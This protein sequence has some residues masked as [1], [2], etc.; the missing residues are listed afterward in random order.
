MGRKWGLVAA[1][2]AV[3]A[4]AGCSSAGMHVSSAPQVPGKPVIAVQQ[5]T[6]RVEEA[7]MVTASGRTAFR[8]WWVSGGYRQ[9]EHVA[10]DLSDLIIKDTLRDDDDTFYADARRLI[11]DATT[12]R[13]HLP[14]VDRSGYRAGMT[15]LTQAGHYTLGGSY[16]KAY[17]H[18]KAALRKLA[19]FNNAISA[20]DTSAPAT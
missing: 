4:V 8:H 12:A 9:Y 10:N 11:A 16:D 13:H 15:E 19:A 1:G 17:L 7:R 18:I 5:A 20:W 14:P 6:P 2:L 3:T